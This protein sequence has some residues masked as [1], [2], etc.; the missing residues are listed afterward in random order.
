MVEII[1]GRGL[2]NPKGKMGVLWHACKTYL[3]DDKFR[4]YIQQIQSTSK[5]GGWKVI[6][7][8]DSKDSKECKRERKRMQERAKKR[9]ATLDL[10]KE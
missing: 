1:T 5:N 4:P 8:K 6:F 7:K 3:V 9:S 2:N 10:A